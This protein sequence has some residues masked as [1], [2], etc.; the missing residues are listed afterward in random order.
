MPASWQLTPC[1]HG[2]LLPVGP[3]R[4][5]HNVGNIIDVKRQEC[6]Y[7]EYEIMTNV[8]KMFRALASFA[9]LRLQIFF[10]PTS[11]RQTTMTPNKKAALRPTALAGL[12]AL[13]AF[14]AAPLSA[15]ARPITTASAFTIDWTLPYNGTTTAAATPAFFNFSTAHQV[16]VTLDVTNT[17]FG[18]ATNDIRF[19]SFSWDISPSTAAVTDSTL[20]YS[21]VANESLGRDVV[22]VCFYAGPNCDGGGNGG[23][24]DPNHTGTDGDLTTTGN[25]NATIPIRTNTVPPLDS[26]NFDAKFQGGGAL[27]SI[28]G[29][30]TLRDPVSGPE[31]A[32]F[33]LLG[34][35]VLDTGVLARRP[36]SS[37]P[38]TA[39]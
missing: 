3:Q 2:I 10:F 18:T 34:A 37:A 35:G 36:R 25:F 24:E 8:S 14:N 31:P 23:L 39:A 28:E 19:I 11:P 38:V 13:A 20:V 27:S 21:S 26:S 15:N 9:C 16:A 6:N 5:V 33:A 7:S 29:F 12:C 4:A 32:S 30:E 22:S 1:Y 17:S